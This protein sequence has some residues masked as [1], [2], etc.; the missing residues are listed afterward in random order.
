M[1]RCIGWKPRPGSLV[2]GE[3]RQTGEFG[4]NPSQ[5]SRASM[6]NDRTS[7]LSK[8]N[9]TRTTFRRA[10]RQRPGVWVWQPDGGIE[11]CPDGGRPQGGCRLVANTG[12]RRGHASPRTTSSGRG[13][14]CSNGYL[15]CIC[16]I[17]IGRG[18]VPAM[19][20]VNRSGYDCYESLDATGAHP[21][22]PPRA[23][24]GFTDSH[25]SWAT[26]AL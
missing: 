7:S 6:G 26:R 10:V 25:G 22:V 21:L 24:L 11:S 23:V 12:H 15:C 13:C 17:R 9:K 18:E 2:P 14:L 4:A 3:P 16:E 5:L 19:H 8:S 1:T 20:R